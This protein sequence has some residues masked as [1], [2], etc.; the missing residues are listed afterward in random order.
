MLRAAALLTV[1][2]PYAAGG[3]LGPAAL[4]LALWAPAVGAARAA[5]APELTEPDSTRRRTVPGHC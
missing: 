5:V 3:L 2:A 4:C 1:P